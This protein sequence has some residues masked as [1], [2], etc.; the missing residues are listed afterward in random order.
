M[1]PYRA[2]SHMQTLP[3]NEIRECHRIARGLLAGKSM[4]NIIPHMEFTYRHYVSNTILKFPEKEVFGIR[5]DHQFED[6][7]IVDKWF[8]GKANLWNRNNPF[9]HGSE[10]F[11]PSPL[12]AEATK[13]LCCTLWNEIEVYLGANPGCYQPHEKSKGN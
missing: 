4:D 5:T 2:S 13:K 3:N 9:S 12:S 10:H 7:E 11:A 1:N 8:G 6:M